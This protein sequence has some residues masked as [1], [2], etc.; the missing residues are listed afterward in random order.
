MGKGYG[1]KDAARDTGVGTKKVSKNWHKAR[2]DAR[3]SGEIPYKKSGIDSL[4]DAVFGKK[5]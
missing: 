1:K 5:K 2:N 4:I 3:R